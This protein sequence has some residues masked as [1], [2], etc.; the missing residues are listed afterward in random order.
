MLRLQR[1][2]EE[3]EELRQFVKETRERLHASTD[4][5]KQKRA[6]EYILQI[7]LELEKVHGEHTGLLQQS[8]ELKNQALHSA[9]ESLYYTGLSSFNFDQDIV[10]YVLST[11]LPLES[12]K[13]AAVPLMGLQHMQTWSPLTVFAEQSIVAGQVV[14]NGVKI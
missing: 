2:N 3:F 6:H 7:A 9:K 14:K 12:L 1:E 4:P 5:D 8:M 13:A 10:S 11:P